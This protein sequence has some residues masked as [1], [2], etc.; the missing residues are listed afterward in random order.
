MV[1]QAGAFDSP[2]RKTHQ[3]GFRKHAPLSGTVC[4]VLSPND[5]FLRIQIRLLLRSARS[6]SVSL[7]LNPPKKMAESSARF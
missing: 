3:N 1:T 5:V 6:G 7:I 4:N 2:A